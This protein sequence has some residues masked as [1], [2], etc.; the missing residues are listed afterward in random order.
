MRRHYGRSTETPLE[1][2]LMEPDPLRWVN[3]PVVARG[4][5][6][7]AAG[8][9]IPEGSRGEVIGALFEL[10][11]CDPTYLEVL[12]IIDSKRIKGRTEPAML[13][14]TSRS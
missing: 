1:R 12:F 2:A 9:L 11:K 6:R 4:A 5:L 10:G 3:A 14:L 7:N 13:Y 8:D